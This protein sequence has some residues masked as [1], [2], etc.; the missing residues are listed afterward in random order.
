MF[1]LI[2]GRRLDAFMLAES[3]LEQKLTH[4]CKP[5]EDPYFYFNVSTTV[6]SSSG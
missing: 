6:E 4:I 1:G 5:N 2:E 3:G